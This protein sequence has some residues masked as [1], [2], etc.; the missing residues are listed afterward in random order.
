V[1][2]HQ[3][4]VEVDVDGSG[5]VTYDELE[6]ATRT[7]LRLDK[8]ELP[9]DALKALW[10]VLDADDSDAVQADEFKLF[11][12]GQC[13][14][15]LEEGRSRAKPPPG[16]V[17]V[18]RSHTARKSPSPKPARPVFDYD[19]Y[20]ARAS[21]EH[22]KR[23][24]ALDA[25]L[26]KQSAKA[27]EEDR[28]RTRLVERGALKDEQRKLCL[29][30][31]KRL[32]CSPIPLGE[33]EAGRLRLG[34]ERLVPLYQSER[35]LELLERKQQEG[36]EISTFY[37]WPRPSVS[38]RSRPT[39]TR[40]ASMSPG[41]SSALKHLETSLL[42]GIGRNRTPHSSMH[43]QVHMATSMSLPELPVRPS[44]RNLATFAA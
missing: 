10:C 33:R 16:F 41:A 40:P 1:T 36:K 3:L 23:M 2:W 8:A 5:F 34:G 25:R 35:I 29:S 12:T 39:T 27:K 32:V 15:L 42:S 17:G 31:M 22:E 11:I 14:T 4:F 21:V 26:A 30:T 19:E 44:V 13:A 37:S 28:R 20:F 9:E 24:V 6:H 38:P 18:T 43:V 7:K